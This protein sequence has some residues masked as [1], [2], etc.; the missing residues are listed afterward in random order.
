MTAR[1]HI[2]NAIITLLQLRSECK[3]KRKRGRYTRR[4]KQ[5]QDELWAMDIADKVTNL[6]FKPGLY[7]IQ[8][9]S[10]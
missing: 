8:T 3:D 4:I 7:E 10:G 1:D 6:N 9:P 2:N 5:L